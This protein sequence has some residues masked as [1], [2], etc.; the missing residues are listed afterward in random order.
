VGAVAAAVGGELEH[1]G[2]AYPITGPETL[3]LGEVAAILGRTLGRSVRYVD[4]DA[5][6]LERRLVDAGVAPWVAEADVELQLGFAV[7]DGDLVSDAVERLAM[8]RP[9][10]F[11]TFAREHV[12]G[13][14]AS[15]GV[16]VPPLAF[17]ATEEVI[18]S[19]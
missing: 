8:R 12:H 7:G 15:G 1:A 9:R 16:G 11:D 4:V 18:L 13:F 3:T 6:E 14:P 5:E 19:I 2:R 17:A 10:S